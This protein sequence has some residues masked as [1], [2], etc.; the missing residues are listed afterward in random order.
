MKLDKFK[1]EMKTFLTTIELN[2]F[3]RDVIEC[4]KPEPTKGMAAVLAVGITG[5]MKDGLE[6]AAGL[7]EALCWSRRLER[8][9]GLWRML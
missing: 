7:Q 6:R 2:I 4:L 5:G 1:L 3:Q 8:D 9:V